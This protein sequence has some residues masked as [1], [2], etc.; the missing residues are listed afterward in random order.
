MQVFVVRPYLPLASPTDLAPS[1]RLSA[2]KERHA[3]LLR[4]HK[5]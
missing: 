3:K 5:L 2:V 1:C 4:V